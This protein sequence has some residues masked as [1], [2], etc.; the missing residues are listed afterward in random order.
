MRFHSVYP[1][2][3]FANRLLLLALTVLVVAPIGSRAA[4]Q[5]APLISGGLGFLSST[6]G[7]T[8]YLQPV[9]APVAAI[10]L[11]SHLLVESRA[12]LREFYQPKNGTGPYQGAFFPTLEYLQLDYIAARKLTITVGRFLTPFGTYNER[13]TPI[14]IRNFQDTPLIFGIGTRTTGS[15]DGVM[16]RGALFSTTA[17]QVNYTG[18]FSV[19]TGV[20]EFEAARSTGGR[21][22][23]YFPGK[24]LELGTSYES[25]LQSPRSNS[26]G[27]DLWWQPWRFP[28]HIRSEYAHAAHAQGYWLEASYRLSQWRGPDSLLGRLEPVFRMQ[29]VFRNSPGPGDALPSADTQQADFGL[30]YHLPNEVRLNTSY[31]R[32]LSSTGNT[33]IWDTSLTYRFLFPVIWRRGR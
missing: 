19:Y 24:R 29:Q 31:S 21:I 1:K 15:S 10:S 9:I 14:W 2:D 33:N 7:G 27:A 6:V 32:Q 5:N 16:A 11:G 30:D 22:G 18:Y 12:D 25:F 20:P 17:A 8:T 4:A 23:A 3:R 26:T 13:L 28:L